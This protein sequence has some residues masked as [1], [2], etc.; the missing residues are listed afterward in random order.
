VADIAGKIILA[1]KGGI[2]WASCTSWTIPLRMAMMTTNNPTTR[3]RAVGIHTSFLKMPLLTPD[4]QYD[5]I[6]EE[7]SADQI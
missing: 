3:I 5:G 4:A 7:Q 6:K 1:R 2:A